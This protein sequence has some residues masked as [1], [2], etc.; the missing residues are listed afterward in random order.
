MDVD[1]EPCKNSD[2]R[3][4][5]FVGENGIGPHYKLASQVELWKL[6]WPPSLLG[7]AYIL[8][9]PESMHVLIKFAQMKDICVCDLVVIIKLC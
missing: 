1:V 3:I 5:N 9:L 6:M 7:L 8:S 2:G 4:Q